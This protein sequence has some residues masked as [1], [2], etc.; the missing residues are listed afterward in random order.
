MICFLENSELLKT[1]ERY[2]LTPKAQWWGCH[3]LLY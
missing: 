3:A 1:H 2:K